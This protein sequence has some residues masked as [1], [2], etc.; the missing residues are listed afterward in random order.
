MPGNALPGGVK[1]LPGAY[2]QWAGPDPS[3]KTN[4]LDVWGVGSDGKI[5]HWWLRQDS[6][7]WFGWESFG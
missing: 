2:G 5:Y 3:Q 1:I 6:G 4:T 7:K